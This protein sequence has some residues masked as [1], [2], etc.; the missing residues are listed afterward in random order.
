MAIIALI[1]FVLSLAALFFSG[2]VHAVIACL[3]FAALIIHNISSA[4]FYRLAFAGL[5]VDERKRD[6]RVIFTFGAVLLVILLSGIALYLNYFLD[7]SCLPAF[8]W[9]LIHRIAAAASLPF[10]FWHM[11]REWS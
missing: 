11:K 3:M 1:L 2:T 6:S 10:L 7:I 8:P 4:G 5:L 9:L